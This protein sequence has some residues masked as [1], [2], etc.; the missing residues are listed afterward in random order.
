[1]KLTTLLTF[2]SILCISKISCTSNTEKNQTVAV[3]AAPS[4]K[5]NGKTIDSLIKIYN[6]QAVEYDNW[7]VDGNIYSC[8]NIGLLNSTKVPN[9]PNPDSAAVEF[10]GIAR[11]IKNALVNPEKYKSYYIIFVATDGMFMKSHASGME[12]PNKLLN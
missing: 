5:D 8:L 12:V 1:M 3:V 6:C 4:Y 11:A 9:N 10:T 7:K 2:L